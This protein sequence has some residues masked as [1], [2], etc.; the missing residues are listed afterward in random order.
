MGPTTAVPTATATTAAIRP[1][2]ML[3]DSQAERRRLIA[4]A[5][6]MEDEAGWLLQRLDIPAGGR[7]VDIGCGPV[8]ILPQL[9][10]RV[11]PTGEV[12][13]LDRHADMLDHAARTCAELPNVTLE[14]GDA[15][16]TELPRRTFDLAH[17]RLVLVNVPDPLAVL[18]E[19]A[20]IVRPGGTVAAQEV[21]WLSW[22]CEPAHPAWTRLR[23]ILTALWRSRN[24]DPFIGRRLPAM[25]E[26]VGLVDVRAM[27]H[28][29]VD[30]AD[31]WYQRLLISFAGMFRGRI[32]DAGLADV[33]ELDLLVAELGEHLATPGT[34]VVRALTVQAWGRVAP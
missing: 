33:D 11:G 14:L 21:D 20:A 34:V 18:R 7:A 22:Q 28:A 23:E 10:A 12:V 24:L 17:I 30:S 5:A 2:Y 13:G 25:L 9:S 16:A 6:L 19:A 31:D 3:G 1:E 29:G 32:V 26:A 27:S 15:V 4:Q 8:G